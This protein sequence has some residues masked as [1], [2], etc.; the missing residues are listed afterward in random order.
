[1]EGGGLSRSPDEGGTA[2]YAGQRQGPGSTLPV[3]DCY[4][5]RV[6]APA[7]VLWYKHPAER[8]TPSPEVWKTLAEDQE[9]QSLFAGLVDRGVAP[10]PHRGRLCLGR[11]AHSDGNVRRHCGVR[12]LGPPRGPLR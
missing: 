2:G 3:V 11:C 12:R 4:G 10:D 5:R 6:P 1:M 9:F 7:Y 8:H